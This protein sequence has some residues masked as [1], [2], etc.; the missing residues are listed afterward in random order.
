MQIVPLTQPSKVSGKIEVRV[1]GASKPE[2]KDDRS[3]PSQD[4]RGDQTARLTELKNALAKHDITLNY[5]QD[6]RTNRILIKLVDETTGEA[7]RQ[8]PNEASLD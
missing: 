7:I 8:I 4:N 3:L 1:D 6:D 5:S 2:I